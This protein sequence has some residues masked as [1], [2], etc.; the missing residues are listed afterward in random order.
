MSFVKNLENTLNND[1]NCSVTENGALGFRTTGSH[2]LDL[3][4]SV[5]SFKKQSR[6]RHCK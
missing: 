3:N 2:L 6:R 5:S 4:F 1:F